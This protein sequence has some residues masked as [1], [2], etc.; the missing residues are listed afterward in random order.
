VDHGLTAFAPQFVGRA[1]VAVREGF[2]VGV[3]GPARD[4]Q[5]GPVQPDPVGPVPADV[6]NAN[7]ARASCPEI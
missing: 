3:P 1:Q 5:R 2:G 7:S 4:G 6:E